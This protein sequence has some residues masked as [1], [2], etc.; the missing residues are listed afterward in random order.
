MPFQLK[1][2][3]PADLV[4]TKAAGV[5]SA[6]VSD[7]T[8]FLEHMRKASRHIS[9]GYAFNATYTAQT[10]TQ[11][12]HQVAFAIQELMQLPDPCGLHKR[13]EYLRPTAFH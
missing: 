13:K 6:S 5:A 10:P 1:V 8:L 3:G 11:V 2:I 4:V 9:H 7:G 12:R